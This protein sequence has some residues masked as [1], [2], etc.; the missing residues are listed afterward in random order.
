M[1]QQSRENMEL[2]MSALDEKS[3]K[4]FWYFLR[5][6]HASL[7]ELVDLID[8]STDMEVLHRL[9]EI[10]N[11]TAVEVLGAP[12]LEFSESKIDQLTGNKIFFSWWLINLTKGNELLAL[13]GREHLMDIF[14]EEHQV[15]IISEMSPSIRVSDSAKVEQRNGILSI[16][17]NKL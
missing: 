15:I 8:A 4:I 12:V 16:T 2:F 14:Y 11:A 5:H 17:L 9:R 13:E 6:G 10:I 1:E 3:R 7:T